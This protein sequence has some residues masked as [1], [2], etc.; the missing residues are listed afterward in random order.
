MRT[1]SSAARR[2]TRLEQEMGYGPAHGRRG[3]PAN[4]SAVTGR[5]LQ[6]PRDRWRDARHNDQDEAE[7][8]EERARPRTRARET[9]ATAGAGQD[10]L[11]RQSI[12]RRGS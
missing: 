6:N 5:P 8:G 12:T 1:A 7:R 2:A 11:G 4:V 10:R 9:P 3:A